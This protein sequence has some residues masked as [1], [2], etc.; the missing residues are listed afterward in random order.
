MAELDEKVSR[1]M[2]AQ[3]RAKKIIQMDNQGTVSQYKA[4][5]LSEGKISYGEDGVNFTPQPT[6]NNNMS[7][8]AQMPPISSSNSKLPKEI[9]ES[10]KV[11]PN[12][13]MGM[14]SNGSV[15]DI[16]NDMSSG[17]LQEQA[18][19]VQAI[20]NNNNLTSMN[21]APIDY[22]MIK[23]IVEDCMKKYVSSIKKSIL[24]ESKE[25]NI[26]TLQAMKIGNKFSFITNTGDL[27]EA[28]LKFV[29]NVK[30]K[31]GGN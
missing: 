4:K 6:Q 5:A 27:Y 22:S 15:L 8:Y 23:M 21:N 17:K 19:Q 7:Q 29:K 13:G 14:M 31:K 24:S 25:N 26:G 18:Q 2:Q 10:F 1:F 16:V 9:L 12:M 30:T 3:E 11:Q 28:E 20:Q